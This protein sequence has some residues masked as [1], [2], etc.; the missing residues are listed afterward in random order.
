MAPRPNDATS[1]KLWNIAGGRS[2]I[3][4]ER[5]RDFVELQSDIRTTVVPASGVRSNAESFSS[6]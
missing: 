3:V 2:Y 5:S 6:F 4:D 1:C